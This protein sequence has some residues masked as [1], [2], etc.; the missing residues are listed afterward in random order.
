MFEL[1]SPLQGISSNKVIYDI[2]AWWVLGHAITPLAHSGATPKVEVVIHFLALP[3]WLF[4]LFV[5]I[6][7]LRSSDLKF[8][9]WADAFFS[10]TARLTR[11]L[12][13]LQSTIMSEIHGWP[14]GA[15]SNCLVYHPFLGWN[16]NHLKNPTDCL[17][18]GDHF[19]SFHTCLVWCYTKFY[20]T[21][22]L[23]IP[24]CAGGNSSQKLKFPALQ[25]STEEPCCKGFIT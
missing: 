4:L 25:Y 12:L 10:Q 6:V 19:Y 2:S 16:K 18:S 5:P 11:N 1:S 7:F 17:C 13:Q 9:I 21:T 14:A 8:S 20:P 23:H 3:H 22:K 15:S 24:T